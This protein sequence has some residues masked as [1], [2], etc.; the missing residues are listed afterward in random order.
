MQPADERP[1][2]LW[3]RLVRWAGYGLLAALLYVLSLGPAFRLFTQGRLS[4]K[5]LER[6]Y[7]PLVSAAAAVGLHDLLVRYVSWW[8]PPVEQMGTPLPAKEDF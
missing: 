2:P 8:L 3:Q 1:E 5:L 4:S 6:T 7:M